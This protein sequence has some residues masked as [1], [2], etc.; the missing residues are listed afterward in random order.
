MPRLSF[1]NVVQLTKKQLDKK[2]VE[3]NRQLQNNNNALKKGMKVL[4]EETNKAKDVVKSV[5]EEVK[6]GVKEKKALNTTL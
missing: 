2:K 3:A 4:E 6:A 1:R 5:A